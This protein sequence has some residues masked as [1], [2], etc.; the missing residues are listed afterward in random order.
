MQHE[1]R[2]PFIGEFAGPVKQQ[3]FIYVGHHLLLIDS[4]NSIM[5]SAA[6]G[7]GLAWLAEGTTAEGHE[8]QNQ[9][10]NN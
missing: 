5:S 1:L 3:S 7:G 10:S 9:Q 2:Y 8:N 4:D 6:F